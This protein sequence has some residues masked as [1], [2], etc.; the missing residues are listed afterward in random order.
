MPPR[1]KATKIA[2]IGTTI[3]WLRTK[4]PIL[5]SVFVSVNVN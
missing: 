3:D 5:F 4:T 2:A 1:T